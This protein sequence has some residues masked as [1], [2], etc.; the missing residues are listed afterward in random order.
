MG[1][2]RRLKRLAGALLI[3]SAAF[4]AAALLTSTP[5]DPELY[6]A[7]AGEGA[8]VVY[9]L[10]NGVHSDLV[11]PTA[12]L[13]AAPG[14]A[15]SAVER[16]APTPWTAIGWGDEAFYQGQGWSPARLGEVVRAL[17][18][19]G[20][21]SVVRVGGVADPTAEPGFPRVVSVTLSQRGFERLRARLDAAFAAPEGEPVVVAPAG[22]NAVFFRGRESFSILQVCNVW[23]GRLLAAAGVPTT[24]LLHAASAG[25]AW[26]LV[27]RAGASPGR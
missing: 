14:P 20:N 22:P 24:P 16:M 27:H 5:R 23:T 2:I 10:A 12:L 25:L 11:V 26:D 19:P 3:L 17:F 4:V 7:K 8:V 1:A 13:A 9:V 15:A 18:R 6:P 21:P